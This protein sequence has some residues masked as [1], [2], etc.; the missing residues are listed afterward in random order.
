MRIY[1][2][3]LVISFTFIQPLPAQTQAPTSWQQELL[4]QVNKVRATG[5]RC[6]NGKYYKPSPPL[7][8]NTALARAA[9]LHAKDMDEKAYFEHRSCD[10]KNFTTRIQDQGYQWMFAGENIAWGFSDAAKVVRAWQRSKGHCKNLLNPNY[11][12]MGA[13]RSDDF[14]VQDLAAPK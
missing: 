6:P 9:Q 13:G 1:L 2:F 5:C 8:W 7:V 10:G 4:S 12:E 11:T 14:W 3:I